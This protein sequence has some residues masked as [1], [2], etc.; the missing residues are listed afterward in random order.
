VFMSGR[1]FGSD[2]AVTL[3]LLAK[4]VGAD[5]LDLAVEEEVSP[6]L[7]AAPGAVA[8]AKALAR[9]LGSAVDGETVADSVSALIGRW[10]SEE[11]REGIEAFF[12]RRNPVWA[13]GPGG[14]A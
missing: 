4:S 1:L 14:R 13:I 7:R 9:R 8:E 6:Y 3:G 12:E 2:E 10:E 5:D 11:A